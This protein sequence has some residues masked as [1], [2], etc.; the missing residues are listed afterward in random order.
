VDDIYVDFLMARRRESPELDLKWTVDISKPRFAELAK[1]IFAMSNYG[2]GHVLIGFKQ[3]E[4]GGFEPTGVPEGFH[5][6]QADLQQKFNAYSSDP[7]T[8]G[9]RE[10]ERRI[11]GVARPFAIVYAPAS[12]TPLY[13]KYD[14]FVRAPDGKEKRAFRRGDVLFRRGTQSIVASDSEMEFIKKRT[15]QT[16]YE[17]SL[18][19]GNPD[20]I[21]E[22]MHSN[23]FFVRR[24]PEH[25][26]SAKV[27]VD[28]V[29]FQ[30]E[31]A[32]PFVF[33]SPWVYAFDDPSAS[34]LRPLVENGTVQKHA[35][36]DWL[37]DK[38]HVSHLLWL[39]D[40]C[41]IWEARRLG[42]YRARPKKLFYP[43]REGETTRFEEWPGITRGSSRQV[44]AQMYAEQL[45]ET[46][47]VHPAADVHFTMI[48]DRL[49][50]RIA[51]SYVLT[52]DGRHVRRGEQ[53]GTII[54]RLSYD[55]YNKLYLRNV[56]FWMSKLGGMDGSLRVLDGRIEVEADSMN[57][58]S[59]VGLRG[60]RPT[61]ESVKSEPGP[62]DGGG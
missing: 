1:D 25:V 45:G 8:I 26:F 60:D 43:V 16:D 35:V 39:L 12:T 58:R 9:Y 42:M 33:Q 57:A 10:F 46:V 5:I 14:G 34:P 23:L 7:I 30:A 62:E 18:L 31:L 59:A 55:E 2:G 49:F 38:D 20:R 6:D 29:P 11:D 50:L 56:L 40:Q 17:I 52:A 36:R 37:A 19:S 51:P 4:K 53:E 13:P 54:T 28:E 47:W 22:T 48:G 21:E 32:T 27:R 3:K 61:L 41:L 15:E 24:F 44:A